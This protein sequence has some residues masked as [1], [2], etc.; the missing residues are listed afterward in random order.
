MPEASTIVKNLLRWYQLEARDLPWR[1]VSDP[2]AIWISEIMLQ[3]TQVKTVIPY[4]NR[5]MKRFPS[6]RTLALADE[7]VVLKHWEGL[8]YYSRARNIQKAAIEIDRSHGG[9]FPLEFDVILSLPGIGP[10][11]AGA[12]SSISY[13]H[14]RPI[15]DGNVIR[16]LS[17][18]DGITANTK[19]RQTNQWLWA[20]AEEFVIR[21]SKT[22]VPG[23]NT[24]G[25]FNQALMELGATICLPRNPECS[26]CPVRRSCIAR[27]EGLIETIPDL[28]KRKK[29]VA[30]LFLAVVARKSGK[31]LI[32]QR[33]LGG[34]NGRLWEF[35]NCEVRSEDPGGNGWLERTFCVNPTDL[36]LLGEV[37]HSITT[38]RITLKVY[39]CN[40]ASGCRIGDNSSKWVRGSELEGLAFTAAHRKIVRR[41][42]CVDQQLER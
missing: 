7:D 14:A 15:V 27:K 12:I 40:I 13:G 8:G 1:R 18:L 16:V 42:V 35:P 28:G 21:A 26:K 3:Q 33:E 32:R 41:F 4:W 24:C 11:T 22:S 37:K 5:W 23:R 17:R 36:K 10:Y 20:R 31:F 2:Y 38:N 9:Q 39:S 30:R 19:L 6:V 29:S 25:D 34:I